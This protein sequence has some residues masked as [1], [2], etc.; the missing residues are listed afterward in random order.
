MNDIF[1]KAVARNRYLSEDVV[2]EM[3]AATYFGENAVKAGLADELNSNFFMTSENTESNL[4][5]YLS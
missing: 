1:I 4:K 2:R 3:Q 5:M